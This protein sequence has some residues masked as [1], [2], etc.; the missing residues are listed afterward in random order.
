[1]ASK[2]VTG[3]S[4]TNC[5][6]SSAQN[7]S[8]TERTAAQ[9]IRDS[10][11]ES[12]EAHA[13]ERELDQ[14]RL[15]FLARSDPLTC[16]INRTLFADRLEN[17]VAGARRD[18]SVVALMFL[19]VDGFK[20]VNDRHGHH[21]GDAL[22]RQVAERLV[23]TVRESVTV[24]RLG[25]DEFTVILEGGR[26]VEDAGQVATNVLKALAEPYRVGREDITITSS[27]GVAAFPLDGETAAEL[28]KGADKGGG[29]GADSRSAA[30]PAAAA[31]GGNPPKR[32]SIFRREALEILADHV[33]LGG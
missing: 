22:L 15:N 3:L 6:N 28:L 31:G 4:P 10:W 33:A 25:G 11:E 27:I 19:D 18:G 13:F 7:S 16:L 8:C 24:A 32:L 9:N 14:Q 2:P 21:V 26:R 23:G 1:M 29:G 17:S 20:E 30:T 12:S 5:R